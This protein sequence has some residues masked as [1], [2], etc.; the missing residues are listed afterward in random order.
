MRLMIIR[1][2]IISAIAA[3]CFCYMTGCSHDDPIDRVS[4]MRPSGDG[5]GGSSGNGGPGAGHKP[6]TTDDA[7][8]KELDDD[9]FRVIGLGAD[10][11]YDRGG[12]LFSV[13]KD[14]HRIVRDLDGAGEITVGLG[15]ES[16]D[17]IMSGAT[18]VV[19]GAEF[20]VSE[21]KMMHRGNGRTWYRVTANDG[22]SGVMVL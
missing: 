1:V 16:S 10:M 20:Q 15:Q 3:A 17:S 19:N 4:A 11:R 8:R 21:I 2:F 18:V 13:T 5:N 12:I 14:G 7:F 22:E 9:V 6:D